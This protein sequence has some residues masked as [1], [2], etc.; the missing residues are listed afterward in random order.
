MTP[1]LSVLAWLASATGDEAK[2]GE[3]REFRFE[4]PAT[5]PVGAAMPFIESEMGID[6]LGR[7]CCALGTSAALDFGEIGPHKYRR[8]TPDSTLT[9]RLGEEGG[10]HGYLYTRHGGFIDLGH[11][12][13][14]IDYT[15]FFAARYYNAPSSGRT[16][17]IFSKVFDEEGEVHLEILP[18]TG[19]PPSALA[20]AMGAKL[21]YERAIW[22]E[23]IT[24]FPPT[25]TIAADE[26]FS[27]FAPEDCFSNA[28]GVL[29]GYIALLTVTPDT[30]FDVAAQRALHKI[31]A[32][33]GP[34]HRLE[35]TKAAIDFVED[36]WWVADGIRPPAKRRN[37]DA[38]SPVKPWLVTDI[39][40]AGKE[41]EGDELR[42]TLA[43]PKPA[44]IHLPVEHAGQPLD[45]L[46][47]LEMTNVH[48]AL[49]ALVPSLPIIRGSDLP[50]VV[51]A[52][53]AE[54]RR[55]NGADA[56]SPGPPVP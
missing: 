16:G 44:S 47:H 8:R 15:R 39:V 21:A 27:S 7:V 1:F 56:D 30:P 13:D 9:D 46:A 34:V 10:K 43:R 51:A 36:H 33:L 48:P 23:I 54:E 22:H 37:F 53:R 50:A 17:G 2:A 28:V 55:V 6:V 52:I 45:S 20:A 31:L 40:I 5:V 24:Y 26:R 18:R 29:A 11:A 14:Y 19:R 4:P 32:R 42:A 25:S 35:E 41:A 49:R 38:F 3:A 12:R